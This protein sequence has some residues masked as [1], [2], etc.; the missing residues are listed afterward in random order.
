MQHGMDKKIKEKVKQFCKQFTF[1]DS[2]AKAGK[3]I[4]SLALLG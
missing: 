2:H 4:S 3:P 1:V